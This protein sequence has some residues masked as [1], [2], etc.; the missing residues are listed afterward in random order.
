MKTHTN[1]YTI[2]HLTLHNA[3]RDQ[4]MIIIEEFSMLKHSNSFF[5]KTKNKKKIRSK[6]HFVFAHFELVAIN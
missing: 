2:S 4:R 5:Q 1:P 6:L 3:K